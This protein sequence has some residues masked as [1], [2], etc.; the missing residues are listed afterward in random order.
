MLRRIPTLGH[1]S[2]QLAL[3]VGRGSGTAIKF[4][5]S[6]YMVRYLGLHE[7][8]FYGLLVGAA[9]AM[10]AILGFGL[11]P[12]FM[13]QLV[14]LPAT[15]AV[16]AIFTR[17]CLSLAIQLVMLPLALLVDVLTG[18][19]VPLRWAPAIAAILLL[20]GLGSEVSNMLTARR[21]VRLAEILLFIRTGLWPLPVMAYGMI[22]PAA[23]TFEVLLAGWVG[24]LVLTW[25]VIVSN[26]LPQQRWRRLQLHWRWLLDGVR[27]SFPLYVHDLNLALGLYLDRF[28][29]SLYIGLELTGVYTFFWSVANMVHSLTIYGMLAPQIATLIDAGARGGE[30]FSRVVRRLQMETALWATL[31]ASGAAAVVAIL[32]PYLHRPLLGD[33]LVV[34]WIILAAA[35]LRIC[36]DGYGNILYALRR[37]EAIA[38]TSL[39]GTLLSAFLNLLL[40]PFAG[41]RGAA[42]AFLITAAAQF[43]LRYQ[44]SRSPRAGA[45]AAR[46]TT[47]L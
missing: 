19:P 35:L 27:Q 20:E 37:D 2:R 31:L 22:E 42:F 45:L 11:T 26:L 4:L 13:R 34:F 38:G 5:L 14:H 33:N 12:W 17:L 44:L 1:I 24:G 18:E 23:R 40:V 15:Q 36:S 29:I 21:H 28:V 8:G 47:A 32:L 43:G 7:L 6:L 30:E 10:P 39:A 16:P 25:L 3:L 41:I 46:S 9:T